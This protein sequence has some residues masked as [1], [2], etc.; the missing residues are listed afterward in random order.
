M[1]KKENIKIGE[2]FK[3]LVNIKIHIGD[4]EKSTK[5]EG[6]VSKIDE[7]KIYI[8]TSDYIGWISRLDF[9]IHNN[10]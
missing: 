5:L 10:G 1:A 3:S 8:T 6:V 2:R 7:D 9:L 4:E